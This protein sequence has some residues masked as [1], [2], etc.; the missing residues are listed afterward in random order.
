MIYVFLWWLA[1]SLSACAMFVWIAVRLNRKYS[2]LR[3][4]PLLTVGQAVVAAIAG[5]AGPIMTVAALGAAVVI[6][7]MESRL[8]R[9]PLI[10]ARRSALS[11]IARGTA[12]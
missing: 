10:P 4:D 12:P 3:P 6:V 2:E 8:W 5:A 7:A 11:D 9:M 1:G